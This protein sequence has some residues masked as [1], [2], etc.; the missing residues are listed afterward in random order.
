MTYLPGFYSLVRRVVTPK[1][2][3]TAGSSGSDEPS[4]AAAPPDICKEHYKN[5]FHPCL[6]LKLSV[7]SGKS[8]SCIHLMCL[9]STR[10]FACPADFIAS[11]SPVCTP[12][13]P[14]ICS[15]ALEQVWGGAVGSSVAQ[16]E[17]L[18]A[19]RVCYL[20]TTHNM[21]F[22]SS[23]S[24]GSSG[25]NILGIKYHEVQWNLVFPFSAQT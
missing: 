17:I 16:V 2:F 22:K 7:L 12:R 14:H 1:A 5:L 15:R 13:P 21:S 18:A 6:H 11:S 9:I 24:Y 25:H 8:Y 19:Q 3:S 10:L 4:V 23:V 20:D